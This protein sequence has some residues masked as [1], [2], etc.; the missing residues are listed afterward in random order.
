[1]A[2]LALTAPLFAGTITLTVT[3]NHDGTFT[4]GYS[5]YTGT[6]P[7]GLA[8]EVA[9]PAG[10]IISAQDLTLYDGPTADSFFD[11]FIDYAAGNPAA[12]QAAAST[13]TGSWL[14]T[15]QPLAA[16]TVPG[17]IPLPTNAGDDFVICMG[18]LVGT[19]PASVAAL[20]HLTVGDDGVATGCIIDL[21]TIRGGIV[22]AD[23]NPMTVLCK[24]NG[25]TAAALPRTFNVD[26]D[27]FPSTYTTYADWVTY[28]K[29]D[30]WCASPWGSGYQCYGDIDGI[31]TPAPNR[32]RVFTADLDILVANWKKKITD[33]TLN[34]CADI[35]HKGTAAPNKYRVYNLDLDRLVTNWKKKDT[36][37]PR[38]CPR[39]E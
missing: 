16:P 24:V 25:D 33:P 21:N 1:L 30:C 38:D 31:A 17:W 3:N 28:G 7:V 22:D 19:A 29:P 35:D 9:M 10:E 27:C 23:G 11:V 32:Y 6:K 20:A 4:V 5:S 26:K 13:A 36:A 39:V 2:I 8:L 18:S 37:L 34:P 12:Y 15:A 14:G